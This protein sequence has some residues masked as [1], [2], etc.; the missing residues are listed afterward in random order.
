[1]NQRDRRL[2][3]EILV[4]VAIKLILIAG[5]WWCFIRDARVTVDSAA[6][7]RHLGNHELTASNP[8]QQGA[9]NAQ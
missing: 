7:A 1:M 2:R 5:L 4:I 9:R 3:K 8:P 6:A